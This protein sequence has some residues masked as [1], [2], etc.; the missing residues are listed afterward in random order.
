MKL[1]LTIFVGVALCYAYPLL[2]WIF[3]LGENL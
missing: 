3:Q 1:G 2:Y